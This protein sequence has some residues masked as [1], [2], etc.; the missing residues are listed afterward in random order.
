MEDFAHVKEIQNV[1]K[2]MLRSDDEV[3]EII[4]GRL[5]PR[6][7]LGVPGV[8]SETFSIGKQKEFKEALEIIKELVEVF[9]GIRSVDIDSLTLQP[10]RNFL[11]KHK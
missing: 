4:E 5:S 7:T 11:E 1:V 6:W 8:D 9:E 10:A 2:G 3:I